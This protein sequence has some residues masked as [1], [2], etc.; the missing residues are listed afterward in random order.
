MSSKD[1][2]TKA[3]KARFEK[4]E[5]VI[6]KEKNI[7]VTL[8]E[9]SRPKR[10]ELYKTLFVC[11]ADGKPILHKND[12]PDPNGD[13]FKYKEDVSLMDEWLAA[14]MEPEFTVEE[15]RSDN[16]PTS[17]KTEMFKVAQEINGITVKEA[18]G[19]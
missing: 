19:N 14:C 4:K 17:L 10:E 2:I 7:S 15:L 3:A 1:E 6:D 11:D 9:I 8:H 5:F 18:A 13:I 16:W 12:K